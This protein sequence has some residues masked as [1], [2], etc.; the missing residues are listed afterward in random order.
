MLKFK[1]TCARGTTWK[2]VGWRD[3]DGAS[4]RRAQR[5]E[6]GLA[7]TA[8][9]ISQAHAIHPKS[10]TARR[11]SARAELRRPRPCRFRSAA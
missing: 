10:L 1:P 9:S 7:G 3:F 8:F 5:N 4:H 2:F 11:P 6:C